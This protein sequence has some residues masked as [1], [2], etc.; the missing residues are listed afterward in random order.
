MLIKVI[1]GDGLEG[2]VPSSNLNF[3][4]MRREI[5]AFKRSDGWVHI[6]KDP[7]RKIQQS[8]RDSDV[9]LNGLS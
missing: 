7:V 8:F 9:F 1:Y 3:L 6:G 2:T 5:I 4:I